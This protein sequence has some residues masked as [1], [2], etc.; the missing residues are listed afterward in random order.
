MFCYASY[1][2]VTSIK[3]NS[4]SFIYT[5]I[6]VSDSTLHSGV[7][8]V[9]TEAWKIYG[10]I[11]PWRLPQVNHACACRQEE[12]CCR[13]NNISECGI[14]SR[15]LLSSHSDFKLTSCHLV[16]LPPPHSAKRCSL[17]SLK[18]RQNGKC[19]HFI[20]EAHVLSEDKAKNLMN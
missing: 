12:S 9:M 13:S 3:K 15:W 7:L 16:A 4:C 2:P 5:E 10:N 14:I 18:K 19:S 8:L 17:L 6:C 20:A 1:K 11:S